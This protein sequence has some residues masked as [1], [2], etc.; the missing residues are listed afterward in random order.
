ME[1]EYWAQTL[2]EIREEVAHIRREMAL[3][4]ARMAVLESWYD[5]SKTRNAS[6]PGWVIAGLGLLLSAVSVLGA[7]WVDSKL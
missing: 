7:L 3:M 4:N 2:R 1:A 5:N 6:L